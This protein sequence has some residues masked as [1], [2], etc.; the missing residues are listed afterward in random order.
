[1]RS[2]LTPTPNPKNALETSYLYYVYRVTRFVCFTY[3]NVTY[4]TMMKKRVEKVNDVND[5]TNL[6]PSSTSFELA[7]ELASNKKHVRLSSIT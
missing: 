1:M 4:T 6:A 2:G 3:Y 5:D 7:S